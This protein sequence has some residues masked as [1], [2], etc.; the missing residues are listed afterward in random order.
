MRMRMRMIAVYVGK[1][2]YKS[3]ILGGKKSDVFGVWQPCWQLKNTKRMQSMPRPVHASPNEPI[4]WI[5]FGSGLSVLSSI[6][7]V[8]ALH[9]ILCRIVQ[10]RKYFD[11]LHSTY[12]VE[13]LLL[14]L[15]SNKWKLHYYSYVLCT[16]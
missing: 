4:T 5:G 14:W 15:H 2:G 7:T 13:T 10:H 1:A 12:S 16:T 11:I 9:K 6:R 3:W 8:K